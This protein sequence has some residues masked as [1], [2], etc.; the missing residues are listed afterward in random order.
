MIILIDN[1]KLIHLGWK[2][3]AS[4]AGLIFSS[5]YSVDE[6]LKEQISRDL[7]EDIY[8]DSDLGNDVKGE[9][10]AKRIYK[11]GYI[12]IILTTGYSDL[13]K[14]DFPWLKNIISKNPPF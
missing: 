1:D 4:K 3:R 9:E 11:S 5:F 14:S 13:N 6:F 7:I 10:E 2:L 8:I 12:N